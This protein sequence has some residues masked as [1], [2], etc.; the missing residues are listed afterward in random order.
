[1]AV[2]GLWQ[3]VV[4][5]RERDVLVDALLVVAGAEVLCRLLVESLEED[6]V[7]KGGAATDWHEVLDRDVGEE[8]CSLDPTIWA[9][10]Y[11]WQEWV[12]AEL[13][14]RHKSESLQTKMQA[15]NI[16]VHDTLRGVMGQS[17]RENNE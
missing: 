6:L 17:N 7:T 15:Y 13:T 2:H 16:T 5:C 3:R 9:F 10:I 12:V 8:V 14:I 1:M 4:V 11:V